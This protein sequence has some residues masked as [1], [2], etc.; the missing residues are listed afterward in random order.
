MKLQK[1]NSSIG[2]SVTLESAA[3]MPFSTLIAFGPTKIRVCVGPLLLPSATPRM[4][5]SWGWAIIVL[6]VLI[7]VLILPFR[8]KTMQSALKMQRIQP[9]M[10]AIKEKYKKY[11]AD[12]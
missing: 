2:S 3:W 1:P 9:Q 7:N 6:T 12:R 5:S 11:K 4:G 10:D 8:V